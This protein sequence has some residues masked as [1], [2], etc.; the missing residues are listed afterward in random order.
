MAA[1]EIAPPKISRPLIARRPRSLCTVRT[2]K[3]VYRST[4]LASPL[5]Q[6]DAETTRQKLDSHWQ[7]RKRNFCSNSPTGSPAGRCPT[8]RDSTYPHPHLQGIAA[9]DDISLWATRPRVQD[10][11]PV[12][13]PSPRLPPSPVS[14][15]F[16]F[17]CAVSRFTWPHRST[18]ACSRRRP[19]G[20]FSLAPTIG[21]SYYYRTAALTARRPLNQSAA[22]AA[23]AAAAAAVAGAEAE[24]EAAAAKPHWPSLPSPPAGI[25]CRSCVERLVVVAQVKTASRTEGRN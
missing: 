15:S 7:A 9:S 22:T 1:G 3:T 8:A 14:S 24:A 5:P 6:A 18:V 20:A 12:I 23:T 13:P 19:P 4:L 16:P 25:G 10:D 17:P 21:E 11:S 2:S